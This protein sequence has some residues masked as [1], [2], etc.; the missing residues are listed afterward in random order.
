MGGGGSSE[1]GRLR[2]RLC[3][4]DAVGGCCLACYSVNLGLLW[5]VYCVWRGPLEKYNEVIWQTKPRAG[6][7]VRYSTNTIAWRSRA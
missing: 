3:A 7:A 1:A 2:C 4:C 5:K 6:R